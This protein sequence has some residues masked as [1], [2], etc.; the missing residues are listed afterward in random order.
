MIHYG[1][2]QGY[3]RKGSAL[4]YLGR[5]EESVKAYEEGLKLDPNNV[6]LKDGLAEVQAQLMGPFPGSYLKTVYIWTVD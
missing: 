2:F 3:S 6:Q 1:L 5:Y 4:A